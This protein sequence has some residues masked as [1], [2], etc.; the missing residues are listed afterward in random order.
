[1]IKYTAEFC[2]C[3][4]NYPNELHK[5]SN[6]VWKCEYYEPIREC[7]Y[8]YRK[9]KCRLKGTGDNDTL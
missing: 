1:M 5:K 2:S 7:E 6:G 9:Q 3:W 8:H 4:M